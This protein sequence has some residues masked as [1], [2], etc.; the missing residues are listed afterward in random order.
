M[1]RSSEKPKVP[2]WSIAEDG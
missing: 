1:E 2:F